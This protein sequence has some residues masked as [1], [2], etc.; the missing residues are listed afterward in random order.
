MPISE[1]ASSREFG[2]RV[3]ALRRA[4]GLTQA[5]ASRG[6]GVSQPQWSRVEHGKQEPKLSTILGIGRGLGVESV[7]ALLDGLSGAPQGHREE[8]SQASD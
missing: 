6:S 2:A 5:E 4:H 3:K 8:S 7:G 1:S